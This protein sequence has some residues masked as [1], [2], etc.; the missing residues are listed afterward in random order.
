MTKIAG[1]Y[2]NGFGA[3]VP[4]V[5]LVLTA[6]TT[7]AGV[8]LGTTAMQATGA[9]GS[10]SFDVL[11]GVYVVTASGVYLGVITIN[12]DSVDGSLNDFLR[13]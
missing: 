7:S 6:R 12:A 10:Y 1:I 3:P 9:D 8:M 13:I 11:P 4:G 5:Q 2:A